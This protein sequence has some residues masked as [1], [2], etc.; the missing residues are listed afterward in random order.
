[1]IDRIELAPL[2]DQGV[3][4][5]FYYDTECMDTFSVFDKDHVYEIMKLVAR[6]PEP[7]YLLVA[8]RDYGKF[9]IH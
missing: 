3:A 2:P 4:I 7:E 9:T 6:E 8:I 1:M 5:T